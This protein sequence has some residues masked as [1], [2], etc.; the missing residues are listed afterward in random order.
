SQIYRQQRK[1]DKAREAAQKGQEIDPNS[2]EIRYN[3]VSLLEAE[4]KTIEAIEAM[5]SILAAT[6]KKTYHAGEKA[7]RAILLERL[8]FLHRTA[9]QYPQAIEAFREMQKLDDDAA[10]RAAVHVIETYRLARDMNK[11]LE[12][13]RS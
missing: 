9:E 1:F 10:P 12:E 2:L 4:G 5:K 3:E 8:G 13:A 11:A 6:A 7:N